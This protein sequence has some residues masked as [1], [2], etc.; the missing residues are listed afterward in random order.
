MKKLIILLVLVPLFCKSQYKGFT[1]IGGKDIPMTYS[2]TYLE[3]GNVFTTIYKTNDS[4]GY[5]Y[6]VKAINYKAEN[7]IKVI[8]DDNAG[9]I[10]ALHHEED[11]S[12]T[13]NTQGAFGR[14]GD[15]NVLYGN[16]P[17][18]CA[19][20]FTSLKRENI[21]VIEVIIDAANEIFLMFHE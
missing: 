1:F 16:Y 2:K 11:V 12:Y 21:E 17:Y 19:V 9:G 5:S 8:I 14:R 13:D 15:G 20:K 18:I 7:K 10:L 3:N 4:Q 6:T